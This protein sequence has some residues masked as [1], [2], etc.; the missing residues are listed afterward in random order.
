M[1]WKKGKGPEDYAKHASACRS[2]SYCSVV[3]GLLLNCC[4][5][6]VSG[7]RRCFRVGV[8]R[9]SCLNSCRWHRVVWWFMAII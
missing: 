5:G 4:S 2:W 6:W 7:I 9:R 3:R 1:L 8:I